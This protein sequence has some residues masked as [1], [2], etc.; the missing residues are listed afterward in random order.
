MFEYLQE[1]IDSS[2]FS[3]LARETGYRVLLAGAS[4]FVFS[5][6]FGRW[7]IS[8]VGSRKLVEQTAKGDSECLDDLHDHKANTPTMGV[9][10]FI[11]AAGVATLLW[12]K[13]D[14]RPIMMLLAYTLGFGANGLGDDLF[15][16]GPGMRNGLRGKTKLFFQ[17]LL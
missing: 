8:W 7:F 12:A 3:V 17:L 14:S 4:A 11:V 10:I 15:K 13:L 16:L 6:I 2:A 9:V 1:L 5:I